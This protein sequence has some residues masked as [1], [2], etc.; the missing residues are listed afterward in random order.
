MGI[1]THILAFIKT[2]RLT[3]LFPEKRKAASLRKSLCDLSFLRC[4]WAEILIS[5]Q[6]IVNAA[7]FFS[8]L[9]VDLRQF[10]RLMNTI[11]LF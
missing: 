6:A 3:Y 2:L 9:P 8:L 5:I 11:F 7:K 1:H 10:F 4:I